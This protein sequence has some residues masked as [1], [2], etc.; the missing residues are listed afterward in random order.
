MPGPSSTTSPTQRD[1]HIHSTNEHGRMNWQKTS[2]HNRRSK[3]DAS[4]GCYKRVIGDA[5]RSREDARRMC[6]IRIGVK[7]LNRM[8]ELGRP[9]C[10]RAAR[11]SSVRETICLNPYPCN[12]AIS[13]SCRH[14]GSL[15]LAPM[16]H[17]R[18]RGATKIIVLQTES[19]SNQFVNTR[20]PLPASERGGVGTSS[21]P[22]VNELESR[23][24]AGA[25]EHDGRAQR[26]DATYVA[27]GSPG[28]DAEARD[29]LR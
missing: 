3:V 1:L 21:A 9:V 2:R 7:T 19:G 23:T 15:D 12:K 17:R 5:L 29:G 25:G 6:E 22:R 24:H 4:I 11:N 16:T 14:E 13:A 28:A 26:G 27:T 18:R 20:A 8:L 10:A